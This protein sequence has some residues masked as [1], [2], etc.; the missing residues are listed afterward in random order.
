MF[1]DTMNIEVWQAFTFLYRQTYIALYSLMSYVHNVHCRFAT[2]VTSLTTFYYITIQLAYG[3][4]KQRL[5]VLNYPF[6]M[7]SLQ[8]V[9]QF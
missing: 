5:N 3:E 8:Q 2:I 9:I 7:Y 6:V 4:E 1:E